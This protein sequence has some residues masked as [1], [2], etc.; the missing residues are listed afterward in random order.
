[1]K[2]SDGRD[3]GERRERDG[4]DGGGP[5]HRLPPPDA[6]GFE[7][8]Y[9]EGRARTGGAVRV[10]VLDGEVLEGALRDADRDWVEVERDGRRTRVRKAR[11]RYVEEL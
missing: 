2:R 11:I 6:T 7:E 5:R 1:M 8:R 10:H 3:G 9:L 4:A